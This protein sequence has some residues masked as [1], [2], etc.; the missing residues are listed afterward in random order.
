[1]QVRS[2]QGA[3]A[4]DINYLHSREHLWR[5]GY[6]VAS[7]PRWDHKFSE[8]IASL[9]AARPVE[10][11]PCVFRPKQS[12]LRTVDKFKTERRRPCLPRIRRPPQLRGPYVREEIF[13]P[14]RSEK[15]SRRRRQTSLLE[16]NNRFQDE[17]WT[18][19]ILLKQRARSMGS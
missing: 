1:L 4:F 2:L 13:W 3:A 12:W 7:P 10:P 9:S 6:L 11:Y 16:R 14:R 15:S 18:I 5:D 19:L 8:R 17:Q